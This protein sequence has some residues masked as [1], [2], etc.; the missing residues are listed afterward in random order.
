MRSVRTRTTTECVSTMAMETN[1]EKYETGRCAA[2]RA[3]AARRAAKSKNFVISL[4]KQ[5]TAGTASD[6]LKLGTATLAT[7]CS[8][9][10]C[11]T[12][13]CWTTKDG[14]IARWSVWRAQLAGSARAMSQHT[15]ARS[16]VNKAI[17]CLQDTCWPTPK[18][19]QINRQG[20]YA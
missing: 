6:T 19:D 11:S 10:T 1:R 13:T 14:A 5:K 7:K 17:L 9:E 4:K 16:A 8:N 2:Q 12:R 3:T 18:K 15:N 20:Y